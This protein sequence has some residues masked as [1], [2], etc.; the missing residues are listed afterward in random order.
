MKITLRQ[1]EVFAAIANHGHVTRAAESIA[2]TQSA[3]STALGE[4]EQQLG[5]LLFE[6]SFTEDDVAMFV[7]SDFLCVVCFVAAT[8]CFYQMYTGKDLFR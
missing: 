1:L 2:M 4:L 6:V 3:A 7:V 5:T 8:A